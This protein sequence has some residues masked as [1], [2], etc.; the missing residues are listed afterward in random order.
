MIFPKYLTFSKIKLE[1][2]ALKR[3]LLDSMDRKRAAR[4]RVRRDL[5]GLVLSEAVRAM[6]VDTA[7]SRYNNINGTGITIGILSDSFDCDGTQAQVDV[8]TGDLPPLSRINV[9]ADYLG[10]G[11]EDE[12]RAMMQ[13]IY[14]IA[15]GAIQQ[16]FRQCLLLRMP[17]RRR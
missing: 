1:L 4:H 14:D 8:Q 15:P 13:L 7:R 16:F 2:P 5:Q 6:F 10:D 12:G 11:C 17:S 9:L 3:E